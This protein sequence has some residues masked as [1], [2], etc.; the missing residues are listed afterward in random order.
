MT[1]IGSY[2]KIWNLGHPSA[3]DLFL[4]EV[5]IEEKVDGSQISF[6]MLDG[7][8]V[9]RSKGAQLV[10]DTPDKMFAAGVRSI[11][12]RQ[13]KLRP[14]WVYRGEY[15][16]SP[17]HNALSYSRIPEGH[18]AI[19]DVQVGEETYLEPPEK[20]RAARELGLDVV[21]VIHRGRVESPEEL[22]ALLNRESYLG[23]AKIEGLVVKNYKRF[24]RDGKALMGK[25]VSEDFREINKHEW[26][27]SNPGKND[28]LAVLAAKYKTSPRWAKA[29]QHLRDAGQL[30][31][32]PRDIG[33]LMKEIHEDLEREVRDEVAEL[34][35]KW[36]MPH[37]KRAACQGF[38][39]WYKQ[40]LVEK[41][42]AGAEG[43]E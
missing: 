20:T 21:P 4:D 22:G 2:P 14:G 42:F 16:R 34:L 17:K 18:I 13:D 43:G 32:S 37:I 9:M 24:G 31:H 10:I 15:L 25:H 6:G 36:A 35:L 39:D 23:G 29:V 1:L 19:F 41:Q 38:P 5:L 40:R 12:E 33:A 7:E 30:E 8:L 3:A 27:K 28:V 11:Q 26:K